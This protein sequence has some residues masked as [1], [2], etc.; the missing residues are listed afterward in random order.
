ML[1]FLTFYS[2]KFWKKLR[3]NTNSVLRNLVPVIYFYL[4][5]LL[6]FW[7]QTINQI[8]KIKTEH[9]YYAEEVIFKQ[10]TIQSNEDSY[11]VGKTNNYLFYYDQINDKGFAIST[12]D[13]VSIKYGTKSF[14]EK[15]DW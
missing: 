11:F 4:V 9:R 13:V 5:I 2:I 12:Q 3:K 14:I 10:D 7:L 15:F 1:V 8:T 6:L